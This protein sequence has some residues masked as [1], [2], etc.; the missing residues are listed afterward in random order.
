MRGN[1]IG[2]LA[3]R[4]VTGVSHNRALV[5]NLHFTSYTLTAARMSVAAVEPANEVR[6]L[7]IPVV[8]SSSFPITYGITR[9][10]FTSEQIPPILS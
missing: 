10:S 5:F 8:T 3:D 9:F 2:L 6:T 4:Q 7:I 1:E